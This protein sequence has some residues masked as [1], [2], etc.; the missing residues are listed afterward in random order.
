[1]HKGT[2]A[3]AGYSGAS[4]SAPTVAAP[5]DGHALLEADQRFQAALDQAIAKGRERI[6]AVEA[7]VQLKRHWFWAYGRNW[8]KNGDSCYGDDD[9]SG[10]AF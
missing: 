8:P 10:L 9:W 1:M 7:T 3:G 4:R 6:E 5:D 2:W